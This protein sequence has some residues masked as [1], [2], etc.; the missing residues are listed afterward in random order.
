MS[1]DLNTVVPSISG[2]KR[3]QDKVL[4]TEASTA[5]AKIYKENTKRDKIVETK[6]EGE[7]FKLKDGDIVI[8]RLQ[9]L[10]VNN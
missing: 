2:P 10:I 8:A 7:D 3:P 9:E 4:L 6:V 1:L 5:F